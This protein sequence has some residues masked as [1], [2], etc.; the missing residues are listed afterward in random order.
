MN[1]DVRYWHKADTPTA[2]ANV[3]FVGKADF[4]QTCCNAG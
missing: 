3:A 1:H 2:A 4:M